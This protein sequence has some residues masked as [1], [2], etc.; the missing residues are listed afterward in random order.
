VFH[1]F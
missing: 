1:Q